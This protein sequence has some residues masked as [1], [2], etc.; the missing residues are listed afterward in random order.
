MILKRSKKHAKFLHNPPQEVGFLVPM[1][2]VS[3]LL[4]DECEGLLSTSNK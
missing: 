1:P 3:T 4:P 2:G